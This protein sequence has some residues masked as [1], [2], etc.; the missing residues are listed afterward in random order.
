MSNITEFAIGFIAG[1]ISVDYIHLKAR[2]LK[3]QNTL[4]KA[5]KSPH[6]PTK[7]QPLTKLRLGKAK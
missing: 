3:E 5:E 1:G 4:R 7:H 6:K 2:E